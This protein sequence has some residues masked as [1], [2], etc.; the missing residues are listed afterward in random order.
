MTTI[1]QRELTA[2]LQLLVQMAKADGKITPA[3]LDSL[4]DAVDSLP[5]PAGMT[6]D[7]LLL[8]EVAIDELLAQITSETARALLYQSLHTMAYIDGEFSPEERE[9]LE[10]VSSSFTSSMVIGKQAWLSE[11]ETKSQLGGRSIAQH[12]QQIADPQQRRHT[13]DKL[14][15]DMC[16]INGVLGAFPIVGVA[17]AFDLLVY[18][19]QVEL[20]QAIGEVWGYSRTR[21]D[22]KKA[23]LE[24]LGITGVRIAVSNLCKFIPVV[25]MVVGG[26]TAFA[27]TWAIGRVADQYFAS[28]CT[29]DQ[30]RLKA[31][32]RDA[33]QEGKQLYQTKS[34]EINA[35]K[36]AIDPQVQSLSQQLA[37]GKITQA[38]YQAQLQE[39]IG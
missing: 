34:A 28:G 38:E 7:S 16:L 2:S 36:Q 32:F 10:K 12:L 33:N 37:E 31:I 14:T 20:C 3:E 25:G 13:V 17:I 24:T 4:T 18:W 6:L 1:N 21:A 15:T 30:G 26:T 27:S 8:Q 29:L 23:L 9:L 5:L 35:K 22:L 39:L 19:N 11:L